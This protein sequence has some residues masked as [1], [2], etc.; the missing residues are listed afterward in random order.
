M[1]GAKVLSTIALVFRQPTKK[2]LK[3]K[4][5]IHHDLPKDVHPPNWILAILFD[6]G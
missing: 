5:N 4:Q 6:G 2:K 1:H 3:R